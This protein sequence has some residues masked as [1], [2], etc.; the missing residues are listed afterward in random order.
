MSNQTNSMTVIIKLGLA[1]QMGTIGEID[2]DKSKYQYLTS[3]GNGVQC[4]VAHQH[5]KWEG[6]QIYVAIIS[7]TE[8]TLPVY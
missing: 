5:C 4:S 6:P 2:S 3:P 1:A 8:R 7:L